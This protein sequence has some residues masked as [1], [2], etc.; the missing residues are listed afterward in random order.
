[1]NP[2]YGASVRPR[3][4]R[5]G[6]TAYDV[7]YRID[8]ASRTTS[9]DDPK[10]AEKWKGIVQ[11]V[12]PAQALE[13]LKITS[14]PGTP[15]VADYADQYINSKS[16]VEPKTL[17]HY[18][19]FMRLHIGPTFGH[20]PMDAV[21]AA[22]VAG[23]VNTMH[24]AGSSA[25]SIQNR[26]GFMSGMFDH[27]IEANI[28]TKNPCT[29]TRLP[30]TESREMVFLTPNEYTD[31][32][33]YIP[34]RWQPLV[35][36]LA[37]TGAR[38]G[39]VTAFMPGDFDLEAERPYV[40]VS[41]AWKS[42]ND[43]GWYIGPPKTKRSKRII[44]L[45]ASIVP[46][47]RP[48]IER[49]T[50][51]VFVNAQGN[52]VRQAKFYETVWAPARRLANGLPAFETARGSDNPW[53]ARARGVWAE[54]TPAARP[55]GKNPRVHDL[56]HSHVSWLLAQGV[57]IDVVSRRV[58][59]ESIQTTVNVYGHIAME[60]AA[61]AADAVGFALSGAMPELTT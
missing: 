34:D 38:W 58:G 18:R 10:A 17:Q 43:K 12:G 28:V 54:K 7:R 14:V 31:L 33:S 45:P 8:G 25:K 51:Y 21:S 56:R 23:W 49:A 19:M 55:L 41:R 5:D 2:T 39:E 60:R 15:T 29:K 4:R 37:A 47:L 11:S 42:A 36:T 52:P 32:L 27:A 20:L 46:V 61:G 22:A 26:H 6:S 3:P 57:G 24:A 50:T 44:Y 35:Q 48:L 9:F 16:G 1:M 40:R 30:T 13:Y 59:H 53:Q